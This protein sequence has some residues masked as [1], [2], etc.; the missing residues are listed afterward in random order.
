MCLTKRH[1]NNGDISKMYNISK[2]R[3]YWSCRPCLN[4][5]VTCLHQNCSTYTALTMADLQK[6]QSHSWTTMGL[7]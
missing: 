7:S 2:L 3:I 4:C 1:L 6:L 5:S